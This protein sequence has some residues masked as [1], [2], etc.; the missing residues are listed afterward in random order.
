MFLSETHLPQV[1]PI[2]AYT[3][4]SWFERER[5]RI[6]APAWHLVATLD[7]IRRPGDYV[8]L[9]LLGHP[10]IVHHSEH[11]PRCFVNSCAHRLSQLTGRTRGNQ[12]RLTCQ[13]H[14]WEYD[15]DGATRRIPD[16]PS[17][18][19]LDKDR[20]GLVR[21]E[22]ATC[23]Q[24]L[25]AR[26]TDA[27]SSFR[28]FLGADNE[29]TLAAACD[30]AHRQLCSWSRTVEANWKVVIENTLE[31]YHVSEIHRRTLGVMPDERVCEHRL[32][33]N[34]SSFTAPGGVPGVIGGVQ[35][36]VLK[37]LGQAPNG[38]YSHHVFMPT[39]GLSVMDD[40]VLAMTYEPY[41]VRRTRLTMRAF[42]IR[43]TRAAPVRHAFIDFCARK[44][45]DFWGR[46]WGEDIRLYPDVQAG[47]ES[48][49]R[50]GDG[51]LSRREERVHHFQRWILAEAGPDV[52]DPAVNGTATLVGACHR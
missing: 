17:F 22:T 20:P 30:T 25:F 12:C 32:D 5:E 46:V 50:P 8:T 28:E 41:D 49:R 21:L 33:A 34:S 35:R 16:A 40:L 27:G 3:D 47:L 18:R 19:P 26:L 38:R 44:H 42:A 29:A 15:G 24:L 36:L 4:S 48:P 39:L 7:E 31:S 37:S 9:T 13:Y 51:L 45:L 43:S 14:G 2:A 11:G 23:G 1:L 10:L 6:L 52:T